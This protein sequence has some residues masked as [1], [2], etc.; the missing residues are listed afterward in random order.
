MRPGA[1]GDFSEQ[2]QLAGAPYAGH[3]VVNGHQRGQ[4]AF[5]DQWQTD[6]GG[7][8]ELL[9]G[10]SLVR[11]QL[12]TVIVDDEGFTATQSGYCQFAECLQPIASDDAGAAGRGPVAADGEAVLVRVHVGVGAAGQAQML[13]EHACSGGQD[14][15]GVDAAGGFLGQGIEKAQAL[16]VL[17]QGLF[18]LGAL[19]HVIAFDEGPGNIAIRIGH[20]LEDEIQQALFLGLSLDALQPD[21]NTG[22]DKGRA[23]AIDP[24]ENIDEALALDFRQR[25]ANRLADDVTFAHHAQIGRVG[26]LEDMFRAA[27]HRHQPGCLFEHL[28][29]ARLLA[30][31]LSFGHYPFGGFHHHG[32][33]AGRLRLII[34]HRRVVQ[35]HPGTFR[36]AVAVQHQLLVLV[37]KRAARQADLHHVVVELGDLRPAF[38]HFRAQQLRVPAAGEPGVGVV[39]DHDAALAP[40]QHDGRWRK[41][42]H[43]RDGLQVRRPLSQRPQRGLRP[44]E[45]ANQR[46]ELAAGGEECVVR[47]VRREVC[48]WVHQ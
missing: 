35:I 4:P 16:F 3:A 29:Q 2:G 14:G 45:A 12:R 9:K 8:I 17:A 7:N 5:L 23:A 46:A 22:A 33:D 37:R 21:A 38:A 32:D 34:E 31:Q 47:V 15:V 25:F 44:V 1:I 48:C 30:L 19:G 39:I 26:H 10:G 43:G 28:L 20:R 24:V 11:W 41:Q 18:G 6:G 36:P 27:Q 40:E 13:A 42:Q